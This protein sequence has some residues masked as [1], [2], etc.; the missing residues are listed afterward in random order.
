MIKRYK[1]D[2][3]EVAYTESYYS[4]VLNKLDPHKVYK[5]LQNMTLLCYEK[6]GSFCHRHIVAHWVEQST[7]F[8]V[9][10]LY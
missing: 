8:K 1:L 9:K 3:D 10:E 4:K 7:G 2:G 5:D 6:Y